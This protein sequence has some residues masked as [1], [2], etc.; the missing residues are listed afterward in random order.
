[1]TNVK[2]IRGAILH[3]L[4]HPRSYDDTASYQYIEDGLI[5]IE[6]GHIKAVDETDKILAK[7]PFGTKIVDYKNHLLMPGFID[8]HIHYAQTEMIAS[9]GKHLLEWLD[10]YVFPAERKYGDPVYAKEN[11]EFFCHELLRNGTTT[12]VVYSTVHAVAAEILFQEAQKLNM[13][14]V[15]GKTMMDRNAPA[16]LLDN[17]QKAYEESKALIEKW[18]GKNRLFYALTP[19]FAPTSTEE[20]LAV[21]QKLL[22]EF[23]DVYLQ[24]HL[25]ENKKEVAWVKEL[26]PWSKDYTDVYDHY[27]LL[28]D[29]TIM[30]HSIYLSDREFMRLAETKTILC[31]SPTSNFF[32]GS[33]FFDLARAKKFKSRI[34][35]GTDVGGGSS[36]SMFLTLNEAYKAAAIQHTNLTPLEG[37]YT[38]TLGNAEALSL[39]HKIGNFVVGKE[40]D[41]VV[42]DLKATPLLAN[43]MKRANSLEEMLFNLMILGDDRVVTA[44]YV[45]G[46]LKHSKE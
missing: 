22:Q 5:V 17:P 11:A 28:T 19:R 16:Y 34:G 12:A 39:E 23:P 6:D 20:Q 4:H 3:F 43:K 30:G 40:A 18:H 41:L 29:K 7:L 36:F 38:I 10:N 35:I 26:F 37:F 2:A 44:T 24:T 9:Y 25:A 8:L 21:T 31:W 46:E 33:G 13:C 42:L 1:M 27:G 45:L 15:S 32:L 14:L